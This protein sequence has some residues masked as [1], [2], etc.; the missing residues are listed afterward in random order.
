MLHRLL[1]LRRGL[2]EGTEKYDHSEHVHALLV[3]SHAVIATA[4]VI[5]AGA[6]ALAAMPLA[7]I[8]LAQARRIAGTAAAKRDSRL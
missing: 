8:S 7:W 6:L 3:V 5:A 1:R 4:A 2:R